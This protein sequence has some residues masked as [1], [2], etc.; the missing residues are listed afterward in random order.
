ML[1]YTVLEKCVWPVRLIHGTCKYGGLPFIRPW[2][3]NPEEGPR[4]LIRRD[5]RASWVSVSAV[6]VW[7]KQSKKQKLKL[8]KPKLIV[9]NPE[10]GHPQNHPA[11]RFEKTQCLWFKWYK[12]RLSSDRVET[13]WKPWLTVSTPRSPQGKA[14]RRHSG[15]AGRALG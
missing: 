14:V 10:A 11:S 3:W 6:L 5:Q 15:K 8:K 1:S 13:M 9:C 4:A 7:K 12:G 2:E